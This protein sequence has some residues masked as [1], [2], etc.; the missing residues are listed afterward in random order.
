M[1]KVVKIF[2][3]LFT[4][5]CRIYIRQKL[6]GGNKTE[7]FMFIFEWCSHVQVLCR[8]VLRKWAQERVCRK[9]VRKC[10]EF[11]KLNGFCQSRGCEKFRGFEE[12]CC[13][14]KRFVDAIN[15]SFILKACVSGLN[16]NYS[17]WNYVQFIKN[18][19]RLL[20]ILI[21]LKI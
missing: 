19:L 16:C 18:I 20:L 7:K 6:L 17:I 11:V 13:V 5:N 14:L 3:R 1:E 8:K 12:F 21:M 4:L 9:I 10:C 15:H 2:R